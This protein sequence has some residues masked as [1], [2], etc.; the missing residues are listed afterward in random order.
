M[1]PRSR[2]NPQDNW[3]AGLAEEAAMGPGSE[4]AAGRALAGSA[5]EAATADWAAG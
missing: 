3:A 2:C 5:G 1:L 4:E